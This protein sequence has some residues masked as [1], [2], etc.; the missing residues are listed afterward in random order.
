MLSST[1]ILQPMLRDNDIQLEEL[2]EFLIAEPPF[3]TG[4]RITQTFG[5]MDIV[6]MQ[7]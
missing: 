4:V 1:G 7:I 5:T 6:S 3:H 2:F